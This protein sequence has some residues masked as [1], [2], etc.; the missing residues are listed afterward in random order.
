[1]PIP[2]LQSPFYSPSFFSGADIKAVIS[3]GDKLWVLGEL[4]TISYSVHRE[5]PSVMLL[6]R[7][8]PAG[9][10]RG[11]RTIAGSM[12]FTVFNQEILR[13]I[14]EAHPEDPVDSGF[15]S[16]MSDQIPPFNV[17]ISFVNEE[18]RMSNIV[19]YGIEIIDDGQ[20]M[21]INDML[22]ENTKSYKARGIDV[23]WQNE[24]GVWTD[25]VGSPPKL[26]SRAIFTSTPILDTSTPSTTMKAYQDALAQIE[27]VKKE[28]VDL[29]S[30]YTSMVTL[31]W[32]LNEQDTNRLEKAKKEAQLYILQR[33][34]RQYKVI[35]EYT[36]DPQKSAVLW[37][38]INTRP[39]LE[40]NG[41]R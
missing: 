29:D 14:T 31:G 23:M 26:N 35:L 19:I 33:D 11:A 32:S 21:S 12:I 36:I 37:K 28:I 25:T 38:N 7:V 24:D 18:G 2:K 6:G 4:Q 34:A 13:H 8:S 10:T 39:Y 5:K 3:T 20:V 27:V 1:M 40:R 16:I 9:F 15:G 30:E 22:I 17:T 41:I